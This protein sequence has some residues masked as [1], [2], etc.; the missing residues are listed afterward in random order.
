MSA[1]AEARRLSLQARLQNLGDQV[2]F[3]EVEAELLAQVRTR[4]EPGI[5]WSEAG[6]R[7]FDVCRRPFDLSGFYLAQADWGAGTI[8]FPFFYEAGRARF[9]ASGPLSPEWGLT[10]RGIFAEAPIYLD[11]YDACRA[12]GM[13]LT[14]PELE[15]GLC[16]KS[17]LGVPLAGRHPGRPTGLMGFH[18]LL[19]EAFPGERR[20][21]MGLVGALAAHRLG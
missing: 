16:T 9:L 7:L 19:P 2:R 21:V 3:L 10:G 20:R 1:S 13:R 18:S 15:T 4:L 12:E 11:S 14:E 8:H 6:Q 5:T 17:W